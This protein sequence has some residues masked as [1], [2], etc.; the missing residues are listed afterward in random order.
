LDCKFS[1]KKPIS[2]LKPPKKRWDEPLENESAPAYRS[3]CL[4]RDLGRDRTVKAA[5]IEHLK[6]KGQKEGRKRAEAENVKKV[7]GRWNR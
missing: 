7:P 1:E 6:E 2:E 3:F 5:Y 4:Y